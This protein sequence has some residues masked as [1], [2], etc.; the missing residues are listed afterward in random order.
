MTI[1]LIA[2]DSTTTHE[3]TFVY[4][5]VFNA[6]LHFRGRRIMLKSVDFGEEC[7]ENRTPS[8]SA[9]IGV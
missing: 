5:H 4:Q 2:F 6:G 3:T 8:Q 1:L 7:A 9:T